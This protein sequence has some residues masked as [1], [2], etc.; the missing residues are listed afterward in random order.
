MPKLKNKT[1]NGIISVIFTIAL[2]LLIITFSI[3]LPI[4]FRPF[5]YMQIDSFNIK[6]EV[7]LWSDHYKLGYNEADLTHE[8][9]KEAYDE[10]LDFLT[11]GTEFGTGIFEYSESGKSHFADCKILFDLNVIVLIISFITVVAILILSKCKIIRL[12]KPFGFNMFFFAGVGTLS[13]FAIVGAVAALDF[14]AAFKVFHLILFPGKDNWYF[15]PRTDGIILALPVDYFMSCAILILV[16]II[17][18]S[19]SAI[20][21]GILSKKKHIK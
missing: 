3:G 10:V 1:L 17:L 4:Y 5:Y 15:D 13:V 16:S 18:L 6:E 12:S 8:A 21:Y 2:I 19:A 20:V 7:M 9:I 14:E 11:L